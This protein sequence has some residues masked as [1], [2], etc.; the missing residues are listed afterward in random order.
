MTKQIFKINNASGFAPLIVSIVIVTI[1]SLFTVGFVL[2]MKNNTSNAL[3]DQ[4]N[5][6][7]FY[8]AESGVNDAI[9]ALDNGYGQIKSSCATDPSNRY[10]RNN[11]ID[12]SGQDYY[13]CLLINPAPSNLQYSSVGTNST[14]DTILTGFDPSSGL[15]KIGYLEISWQAPQDMGIMTYNFPNCSPCKQFPRESQWPTDTPGILRI[16]LTPMSNNG[17]T[18]P[19]NTSKSYTAF[20]Y[21]GFSKDG[22]GSPDQA[23]VYSSNTF[24]ANSGEIVSGNCKNNNQPEDCNVILDVKQAH[25]NSFILSM[26]SIYDPTQVTITAYKHN[27]SGTTGSSNNILDIKNAQTLIDSTG[28]DQGV[29]KRIQ[30]RVPYLV[31]DFGMPSFSLQS[32]GT[33]CSDLIAYPTNLSTGQPGSASS[34]CGL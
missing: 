5:N 34:S 9:Q 29:L 10:L 17:T 21:P 6:G 19:S 11:K 14:T 33:I 27:P 31:K 3:N 22:T 24:G 4:L 26:R 25:T 32:R 12:S 8:A 13:S 1:L 15:T 23:P 18:I 16:L 28:D 7:A 20:L 2:L 30:V